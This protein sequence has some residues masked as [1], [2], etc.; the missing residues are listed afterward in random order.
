MASDVAVENAA[1][2]MLDCEETV[3][4]LNVNVGTVNRSEGD[5]HLAMVSQE[6]QPTLCA[7]LVTMHAPKIP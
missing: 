3:Q 7:I 2:S 6:S 1:A 4:L 5:D